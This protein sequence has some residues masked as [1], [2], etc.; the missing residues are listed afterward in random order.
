MNTARTVHEV[1]IGIAA[2]MALFAGWKIAQVFR[3]ARKMDRALADLGAG[4]SLFLGT[5]LS[6]LPGIE[7]STL[8]GCGATATEIIFLAE[9]D[10]REIGR[11]PRR[12]ILG[13]FGGDESDTHAHL[14]ALDGLP[15]LILAQVAHSRRD[16][17]A[18]SSYTVINWSDGPSQRKQ[19]VFQHVGMTAGRT[20]AQDLDVMRGARPLFPRREEKVG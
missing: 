19:I 3:A 7:Q 6:G 8:V 5:C 14:A 4:R 9:N 11:I 15:S 18:G 12:S 10:C 2:L 20:C 16:R 1:M 17:K 13:V